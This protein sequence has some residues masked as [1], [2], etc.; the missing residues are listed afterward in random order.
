M[1]MSNLIRVQFHKD[2]FYTHNSLLLVTRISKLCSGYTLFLLLE[3]E[4]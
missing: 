4:L 2:Y 1:F 3:K